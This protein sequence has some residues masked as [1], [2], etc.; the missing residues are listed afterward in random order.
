VT[1]IA[2]F[3]EIAFNL[4][5]KI[6]SS[7]SSTFSSAS[8][9]L[10]SLQTKISGLKTDMRGLQE[11]QRS[12]KISAD[13]YTASYAKMTAQM[14]KAQKH[15]KNLASAMTLQKNVNGVKDSARNGMVTTGVGVAAFAGPVAAAIEF[16]DVMSGIARQVDGAKDDAGN[17][18]S[19]YYDMGRQ[20]MQLSNDIPIATK[21]IAEMVTAGARMG[22]AKNELI[23]YV[24]NVSKMATAFEMPAAEIAESMGK[25]AKVMGRP[26]DQI[27]DLADTINY[28]DDNAISK[29]QDIIEVMLR[30]GGTAKQVGLADHNAA[31]LAS[32][33]LTLGKTPQVAATASNALMRELAI[34]T[35]Q[36]KRFQEAIAELGIT[37]EEVQS[38][39]AKDAQG[40]ILKILDMINGLDQERQASITVGLFGKEYGDDVATLSGSIGEYRRQLELLNE[41]KRKGSMDREYQTRLKLTSAHLQIAKNAAYNAAVNMG[42]VL[43]P[44]V[45]DAA[46][47]F[48]DLSQKL[49]SFSAAHPGLTT[50]TIKFAAGLVVLC[51]GVATTA[52]LFSNVISPIISFYLWATKIQLATQMWTAAQ[53]LWNTAMGIGRI[54]LSVGMMIVYAGWMLITTT[55]TYAW[56]AAQWLLNA[57]MAAFP[58]FLIIAG[59]AAIIAAGYYLI[60]NWDTIKAWFIQLWNDPAAAIDV[61]CNAITSKF[62]TAFTWL[63]EKWTSLKSLFSGNISVPDVGMAG[64]NIDIPGHATGGIFDSPHLAWFAEAGPEAAIPLDG[65]ARALSLWAQ[66]GSALGVKTGGGRGDIYLTYSPTLYGGN[67]SENERVLRADKDNLEERLRALESQERRLSYG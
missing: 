13:E 6:E 53:W 55:A 67:A 63:E 49:E 36:P 20:I 29:G 23:D 37:S 16:E 9:Q 39:M 14:E 1:D 45:A 33:F 32:T 60:T 31:A 26:I 7:F 38:G 64:G 18:T 4:A 28:L 48:L 10:T 47:V 25:I 30:I 57:A 17:L 50:G 41:E 66:A 11:A 21:D 52:F 61:F 22:I 15:Q 46:K 5:G 59:I 42:S 40:T 51:A 19:V 12:G 34:A 65:S 2:K 58:A 8:S 27:G 3:Y 43:T 35:Q 44:A 24:K 62:S 56:T 54:L